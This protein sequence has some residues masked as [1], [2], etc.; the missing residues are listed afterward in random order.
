MM[1]SVM[2]H[3]VLPS[4]DGPMG[5]SLTGEQ[6]E[7]VNKMQEENPGKYL[8]AKGVFQA[9]RIIQNRP[10]SQYLCPRTHLCA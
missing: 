7:I 10:K 5:F 1:D 8:G 4:S 6:M 2:L 3:I 9:Q